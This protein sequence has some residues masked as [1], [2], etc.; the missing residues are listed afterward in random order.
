[1]VLFLIGFLTGALTSLLIIYIL[2][3]KKRKLLI[4]RLKSENQ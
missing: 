1:M 3:Y 2:E 4:N